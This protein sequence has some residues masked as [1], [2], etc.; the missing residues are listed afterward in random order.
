MAVI[1]Q[2]AGKVQATCESLQPGFTFDQFLV[3]FQEPS[4]KNWAKVVR[5]HE[6]H[7]RK[8]KL[9]KS[10]PMPHPKQ[11]MQNSLNFHLRKPA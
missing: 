7:E 5:E 6:K 9:G 4:P 1:I 10:H 2:K 11:Y 8:T 3:A